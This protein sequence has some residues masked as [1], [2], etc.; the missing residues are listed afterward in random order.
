[1][2]ELDYNKETLKAYILDL[3]ARL[4]ERNAEIERLTLD[5]A[6]LVGELERERKEKVDER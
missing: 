2:S 1:M 5:V 6:I 3:E 4:R